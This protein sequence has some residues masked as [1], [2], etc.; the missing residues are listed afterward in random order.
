MVSARNLLVD[1]PNIVNISRAVG[2]KD[3]AS[4][5]NVLCI[6]VGNLATD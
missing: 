2:R 4:I 1:S 5:K 3:L 6:D